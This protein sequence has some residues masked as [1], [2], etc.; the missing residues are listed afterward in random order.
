VAVTEQ[1]K[2]TGNDK[3][4]LTSTYEGDINQQHKKLWYQFTNWKQTIKASAKLS[5]EDKH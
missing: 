1:L 4:N 2:S 5:P 3:L